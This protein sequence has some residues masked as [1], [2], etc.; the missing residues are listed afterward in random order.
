MKLGLILAGLIA[1]LALSGAAGGNTADRVVTVRSGDS[2]Q[3]LPHI[4]Y[5]HNYG[6]RVECGS[7]DAFPYVE[8]TSI[9]CDRKHVACGITVKVHT[10][11]D[12]QGGH[13]ARVYGKGGYPVYIFTAM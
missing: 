3:F 2:A 9:P 10:L 12:P 1:G 11:R 5:C 7:G 13:L 6:V 8:L 4:Y